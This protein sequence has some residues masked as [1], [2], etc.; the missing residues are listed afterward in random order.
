MGRLSLPRLPRR[1]ECLFAIQGRPAIGALLPRCRRRLATAQGETICARWRTRHSHRWQI[2][3]RRAAAAPPS[4][5]QPRA[6]TGGGASSDLH[7]LRYIGR[8]N[9]F[10]VEGAA[11]DQAAAFG[12]IRARKFQI[13][14]TSPPLAGDDRLEE[15]AEVV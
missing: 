4:R 7:R 1:R 2:V 12:K 11:P 15:S 5:R 9:A 8:E 6:K 13:E 10:I 14:Q 3:V